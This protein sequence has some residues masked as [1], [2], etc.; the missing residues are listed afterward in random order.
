MGKRIPPHKVEEIYNAADVV[1]ILGEYLQMKK[2]GSNYFALSPFSN[3]KTP[4][5]AVS[6]TKNIWKDFST[7]KG[8]NAVTFLMEAEGMSYV[9]ALKHIAER[10]NI[11]L[12]MEETPEDMIREDRRESLYVLN[13]FAARFFHQQLL[14]GEGE[15]I[16]LSYF[17]E[18]GILMRTVEEFQLGY[19]PTSW[20]AFVK[21]AIRNQYQEQYILDTG[22]A[23]KSDRDG[24]LL[25]RFRGRIMFPIHNH[26]GKVVGFGGRI[27]STEK[28]MAKYINS[29][30][31]EVYQKSYILYGLH[32]GKKAIRDTDRALLVEG[33][34]DVIALYQA[35]IQNV[36]ASSGTALTVEQIR[37]IKRFTRNVLLIYDA[38]RAGLNAALR[39]IDLL[40]EQEMAVK[41]LLLPEGEDPD[42]YVKKHG[43]S[44]FDS[45]VADHALDFID[46]K[47]N[48]LAISLDWSDPQQQPVAIHETAQTVA[49]IPDAVK[50]AIYLDRAA[51]KLGI[52]TDVMQRSLNRALADIAKLQER[53]A[54]RNQSRQ[55]VAPPTLPLVEAPPTEE[56]IAPTETGQQELEL[57]RLILNH[58]D[59]EIE[60]DEEVFPLAEYL[61]GEVSE[62]EFQN[63][64]L[65]KFRQLLMDH[66]DDKEQIDV[67]TFLN[68]SDKQVSNI[69]SRLVTIPFEVSENWEKFDIKA[70][71]IDA[72]IESSVYSALLYFK[73]NRIR[74]LLKESRE[75][76]KKETDPQKLDDLTRKYVH[77]EQLKIEL[78]NELENVIPEL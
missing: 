50:Q 65:E 12:E 42:S 49:K 76:L 3:E 68:H 73:W 32:Q 37:L 16:G 64:E 74:T 40:L 21:E 30:E 70:P 67:H 20:D 38:D 29:P 51:K 61:L 7:G 77:L 36:V 34:M 75:Q 8:G 17:K 19:S 53:E 47:I 1:E 4:S 66:F 18:R 25:D 52:S 69:A 44:G 59:Q 39:G 71:N 26:L 35:G 78:S 9:E 22:L 43:K 6:P 58:H 72:D 5:F 57:V 62:F 54:R 56:A 46:F 27:L 63:R 55:Q 14:T 10:Y 33:Y 24:K 15:R 60:V 2:R 31:S 11:D 48:Q 23:F 28:K 45:Y 13:S 41:V